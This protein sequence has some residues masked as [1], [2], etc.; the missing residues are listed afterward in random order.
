MYRRVHDFVVFE[1]HFT[2][3]ELTD[4]RVSAVEALA[5]LFDGDMESQRLRH[6]RCD[7]CCS[8][9]AGSEVVTLRQHMNI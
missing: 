1:K 4:L 9:T 8:I 2:V 3:S 5:D 7:T 6:R